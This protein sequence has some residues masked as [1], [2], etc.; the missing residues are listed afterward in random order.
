MRTE[1]LI[2][3]GFARVSG[4]LLISFAINHV[5][6]ANS[7]FAELL[8]L[9]S[10]VGCVGIE[11]RNDLPCRLFDGRHPAEVRELLAGKDQVLLAVAELKSFNQLSDSVL[12]EAVA[13]IDIAVQTGAPAISL[14]PCND[15]VPAS[16]KTRIDNLRQSL[17]ELQPLLKASGI[18]GFIEPLGFASSSLRAKREVVDAIEAL[19]VAEHY[20]LIHDTFH[21]HLAGEKE[22]FPEHTGMV[23]VSGVVATD[24]GIDEMRDS[25]RVLVDKNDRIENIKQLSA[26]FAGGY[27]GPVSMEAFATEVHQLTDPAVKLRESF[28]FI[29]SALVADAA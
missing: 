9:A 16:P 1:R 6:A 10:E 5:T 13:L 12:S 20:K 22:Y 28:E 2:R 27:Q 11:A 18:K 8:E 4:G 23:H 26:L 21:H 24:P 17:T 19:D 14:I 25:H 7:A 29:C 3:C 15:G